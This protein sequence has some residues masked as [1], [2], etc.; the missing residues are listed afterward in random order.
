MCRRL[1]RL[2]SAHAVVS[3]AP[4]SGPA[5]LPE[6]ASGPHR[7]YS[8]RC[9]RTWRDPSVVAIADLAGAR[10][11]FAVPMLKENELIG[12]IT[13]Y[14]QEVKPIYR[15]ANRAGHN[16]RRPG[17]H[18]HRERA[19]AQRTAPN[20]CSSRPR[21]PTCSRSS[22]GRLSILQTVLQT[23]VE[24]AARLCDADKGDI[25]HDARATVFTV[26][27]GLRLLRP[28]LLEY[29]K[30]SADRARARHGLRTRSAGGQSQST[31]PTFS[32]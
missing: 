31:L 32:R 11:M 21:P 4:G 23:L 28:S 20:R 16:L 1:R 5:L 15:Q 19:A 3:T 22:A 29:V 8:G 9:R 24:S 26:A 2:A 27:R 6:P 10:T 18:R 17:G 7:R 12:A 25:I 14:R 13:I 30:D